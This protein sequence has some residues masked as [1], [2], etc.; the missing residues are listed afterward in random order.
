MHAQ[1]AKHALHKPGIFKDTAKHARKGEQLSI[2]PTWESKPRR[3][4]MQEFSTANPKLRRHQ[5]SD[6]STK[7][8]SWA[9]IF[10]TRYAAT[11]ASGGLRGIRLTVMTRKQ[12]R[13]SNTTAA[14]G[15]AAAAVFQTPGNKL[16][17]TAKPEKTAS[18]TQRQGPAPWEKQDA[19]SSKNG[20]ATTKK[21]ARYCQIGKPEP[22]STLSCMILTKLK[23]RRSRRR[24]H[25][26]TRMFRFQRASATRWN[27]SPRTFA[28][29]TKKSS[30]RSSW[31]S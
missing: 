23:N 6:W 16:S 27:A 7:A 29:Q 1:I 28:M 5:S 24:S 2:A 9:R 10:A 26:K 18:F 30:L 17:I 15:M 11:E 8:S 4:H 20:S 31:Q 22:I 14:I 19:A 21:P 25:I 3:R 13:C 12:R